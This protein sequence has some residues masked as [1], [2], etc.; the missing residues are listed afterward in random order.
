M[1]TA[2]DSSNAVLT[3]FLMID[4]WGHSSPHL[5]SVMLTALEGSNAVL[6]HSLMVDE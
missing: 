2:L 5:H 3:H 6:T 1:L 4:R